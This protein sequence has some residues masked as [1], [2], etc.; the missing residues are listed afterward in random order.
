MTDPKS[1]LTPICAQ[2]LLTLLVWIWMYVLRLTSMYRLNVDPQELA[3]E[4]KAQSIFK[5]AVNPSDNLENLFELPVLFYVGAILVFIT[6]TVDSLYLGLAWAFVGFRSLHSIVHCTS[7]QISYRFA[8]YV[9]SSFALWA[10]WVR[11][12]IYALG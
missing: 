1:I 11:L 4:T 5:V 9:F 6:N 8:F 12:S 7:N 3:D 2:V 10:M